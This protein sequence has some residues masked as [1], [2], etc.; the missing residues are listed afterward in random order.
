MLYSACAMS[1][2]GLDAFASHRSVIPNNWTWY[3]TEFFLGHRLRRGAVPLSK[4]CPGH[5]VRRVE[6]VR[7]VES[8]K[9][10][11]VALMQEAPRT[12]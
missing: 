11:G 4:R 7:R 3:G 6:A 12:R 2:N 8:S 5:L 1:H 10:Q 9:Q